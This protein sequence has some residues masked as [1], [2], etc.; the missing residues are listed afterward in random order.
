[1]TQRQIRIEI[2]EH[3]TRGDLYEQI[4]RVAECIWDETEGSQFEVIDDNDE[5][6]WFDMLTGSTFWTERITPEPESESEP[7]DM[8][9]CGCTCESCTEQIIAAVGG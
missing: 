7:C 8:L 4:L 9:D 2:P 1:M 6:E 3:C 5:G